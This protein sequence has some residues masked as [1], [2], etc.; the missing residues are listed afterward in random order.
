MHA[1][2]MVRVL[3][4]QFCAETLQFRPVLMQTLHIRLC[5]RMQ[6]TT[7]VVERGTRRCLRAPQPASIKKV[8]AGT[9]AKLTNDEV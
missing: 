6:F 9:K 4:Q 5:Q 8:Q 3:A 7:E 1:C 2:G